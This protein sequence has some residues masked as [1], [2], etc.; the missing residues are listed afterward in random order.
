MHG[1]WV[2]A[3]DLVIDGRVPALDGAEIVPALKNTFLE[4]GEAAWAAGDMATWQSQSIFG[5][6]RAYLDAGVPDPDAYSQALHPFPLV[7][8]DDDGQ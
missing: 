5:L 1:K 4:K 2:K 8:L 7:L 3:R 6:T